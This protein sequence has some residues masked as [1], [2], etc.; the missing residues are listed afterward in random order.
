MGLREPFN[1]VSHMVGAGL[2]LATLPVLLWTAWDGGWTRV[3]PAAV[4]AVALVAV[5]VMSAVYHG[6]TH[7]KAEAWLLRLDQSMI[8][9]LI[10][11]TYTPMALIVAGGS[12]GWILF[13]VEWTLAVAGI[14]VLLTVHRA[15]AWIHQLAYLVLGWAAA[16]VFPALLALPWPAFALLLAGGLAYTAG[17]LLYNRD[18]PGT[19]GIGD[20]GVW[21]L[22][23]IAGAG[24]HAAILILYV[25]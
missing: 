21:H 22:L 18:R 24:A 3:V 12:M 23:V 20:H 19:L 15:P 10:A 9:L 16:L 14:V 1:A 4:Y 11:G 8:Y 25:L 7:R 17:S 2:A 5:F 13:I 6:V